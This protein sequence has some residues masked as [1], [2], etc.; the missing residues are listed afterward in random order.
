MTLGMRIMKLSRLLRLRFDRR[1]AGAGLT[2]AQW[3][4][5]A[6]VRRFPGATQREIAGLLEVGEVTVGRSID[7]LAE[8]GWLERRADPAD[9]RAYRIHLTGAIDPLLAELAAIGA[10]E[11]A[12]ALAG[13]SATEIAA[14][15]VMLER[16]AAN[17]GGDVDPAVVAGCDPR[18]AG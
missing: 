15:D 18:E 9:R 1:A 10:A 2:S 16:I 17:L 6:C 13:F 7:R 11:D 4:T 8:A 14:L 5:I 3:R 12:D